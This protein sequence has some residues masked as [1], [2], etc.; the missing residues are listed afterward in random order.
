MPDSCCSI[1]CTTVPCTV[2]AEAP[3]KVTVIWTAGGA[4]LGYCATGKV[5]TA[6]APAIIRTMA[7][8]QAK[9]GRS[10]KNLDT[11]APGYG[12]SVPETTGP[13]M[14]VGCVETACPLLSWSGD[15]SIGLTSATPDPS[16]CSPATITLSPAATPSLTSHWSPM[17][18]S[19]LITRVL[20]V[21]LALTTIVVASPRELC[22]IARCGTSRP[23]SL[24]PS[25]SCSCT[26]MPGSRMCCGLG[27]TARRVTEPVPESTATSANCNFPVCS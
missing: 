18:R 15:T 22:V 4:M 24:T 2:S 11:L 6:M 5:T 1:T 13:S 7:I 23:C 21:L 27:N 8:T 17:A 9:I 19:V 26:N 16:R 10:M 20:T 3:G 12:D 14:P 25:S